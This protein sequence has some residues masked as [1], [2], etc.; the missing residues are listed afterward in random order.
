MQLELALSRLLVSRT[1]LL[2]NV[3]DPTLTPG[4]DCVVRNVPVAI[5]TNRDP[6]GS[7]SIVIDNLVLEN[8]QAA[9]QTSDTNEVVLSGA[10]NIDLWALGWRYNGD[11]GIFANASVVAARKAQKLLGHDGKSLFTRC[12]PGYETFSADR[13]FLVA[14]QEGITNDG[15]GDQTAAINTFLKKAANQSKIAFFPAGIYQVQGTVF[16]PLNSKVQGSLWSQIMG[17][18]PN[19]NNASQPRAMVRVGNPGDVGTMEIVEMLF[20][21]KGPT[22]G[23]ILMEWNVHEIA[24]GAAG[25]WDSHFRVGGG[26]DTNLTAP[27]CPK[28][29]GFNPNCVAAS[30]MLHVTSEASGYFENVWAWAADQYVQPDC[31]AMLL[32]ALLTRFSHQ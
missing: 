7:P 28:L 14:T 20:T 17:T 5:L 27:D 10:E 32:M 31:K 23:A 30:L 29:A 19:F 21:V 22:A 13:D 12:R 15:T 8:V 2:V 25:M 18:G 24:Q 26:L 11:R 4:P 1:T 3:V 9:V 6:T 16:I